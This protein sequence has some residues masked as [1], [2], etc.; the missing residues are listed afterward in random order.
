VVDP[1]TVV[2]A[3]ERETFHV[4][5]SDGLVVA[6]QPSDPICA[7]AYF[8]GPGNVDLGSS[9]PD[10]DWVGGIARIRSHLVFASGGGFDTLAT[11]HF[12]SGPDY[13]AVGRMI[14][15]GFGDWEGWQ[16]RGTGYRLF[17]PIDGNRW[18]VEVFYPG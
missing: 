9:P 1:G 10:A 5:G 7:G 6:V 3:G 18:V 8:S 12:E 11:V 15:Q 14:G 2:G 4:R 16:L 17:W 13:Y